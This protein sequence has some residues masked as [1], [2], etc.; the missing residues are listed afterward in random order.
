MLKLKLGLSFIDTE[1]LK[2]EGKRTLEHFGEGKQSYLVNSKQ[3][4]TATP[5]H[6]YLAI[7]LRYYTG[8]SCAYYTRGQL[9]RTCN[10]NKMYKI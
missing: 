2:L 9:T 7:I 10:K 1:T 8:I 6:C 4:L 5:V 3:R